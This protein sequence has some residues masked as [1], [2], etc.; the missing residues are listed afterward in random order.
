[1]Y[2][3]W[4]RAVLFRV[5]YESV[6][7][8]VKVG[9]TIVIGLPLEMYNNLSLPYYICKLNHVIIFLNEIFSVIFFKKSTVVHY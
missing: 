6:N 3:E 4:L 8:S 5:D 7:H 1:M 2:S 9:A